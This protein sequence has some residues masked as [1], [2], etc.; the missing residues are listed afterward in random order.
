MSQDEENAFKAWGIYFKS[1]KKYKLNE[2]KDAWHQDD[3]PIGYMYDSFFA[4][5]YA[6]RDD[7]KKILKENKCQNIL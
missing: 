5:Y 6:A 1:I 2:M 7:Y 4:G 3:D